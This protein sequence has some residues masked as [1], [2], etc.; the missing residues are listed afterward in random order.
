VL[1]TIYL[2]IGSHKTGTS[3]I[4]SFL[5]N[6]VDILIKKYDLTYYTPAIWPLKFIERKPDVDLRL[7]GFN[8]LKG[9]KTNRVII[10]H[11]NYSWLSNAED[12]K[13]LHNKLMNYAESVKIIV[14]LRRQD[15]LAISQKQE[16][17]KW[18]DNSVAYGH[19]ISAL[20]TKLTSYASHYLDFYS[21]VEKWAS[22]FGE[23]NIIIKLFQTDT[24]LNGDVVDDFLNVLNISAKDNGFKSVGRVNESLSK[25]KQV[26]LHQTRP[27]FLDGSSEKKLL[28]EKIL[29]LQLAGEKEKLLP[30]R[31]MAKRF[32]EQFKDGNRR[33][34]KKYKISEYD[35]LFADDF[36]M[37]STNLCVEKPLSTN[38][39]IELFSYVLKDISEEIQEQESY[40]NDPRSIAYW[41]RDIALSIEDEN[42]MLAMKIMLKARKLNPKGK[43]I[44]QKIN[45]YKK[46]RIKEITES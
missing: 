45:E 15:S 24:L 39:I 28:V 46:V 16:G 18:L 44:N 9:I 23:E 6:N 30:S 26:F 8:S 14:Y 1:D 32:Y 10:S 34:N 37:Y 5:R 19:E 35:D 3:S 25:S 7:D 42:V 11:E 13:A 29:K 41:L 17:T 43:F 36:N 38:E 12:L 21:R 20:P 4:Q 2:H 22:A 40:N 27:Y 33:L 31:I